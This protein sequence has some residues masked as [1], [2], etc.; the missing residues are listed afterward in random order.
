MDA[1]ERL[2]KRLLGRTISAVRTH[3]AIGH[4]KLDSL[5]LSFEGGSTLLIVPVAGDLRIR[6]TEPHHGQ[7]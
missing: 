1:H 6:L 4:E 2:A 3:S 7:A 5:E